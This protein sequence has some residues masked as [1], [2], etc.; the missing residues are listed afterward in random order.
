MQNKEFRKAQ[1]QFGLS[2]AA[3]TMRMGGM[4][5]GDKGAGLHYL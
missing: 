1:K 5:M 4:G 3:G 2:G